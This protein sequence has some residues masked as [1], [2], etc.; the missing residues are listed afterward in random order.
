M[1]FSAGRKIC[2]TEVS[3]IFLSKLW[4]FL[5]TKLLNVNYFVN[6]CEFLLT[7]CVFVLYSINVLFRKSEGI[8][9]ETELRRYGKN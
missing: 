2:R 8:V 4:E 5:Q 3:V 6:L 9:Y 1:L 7:K